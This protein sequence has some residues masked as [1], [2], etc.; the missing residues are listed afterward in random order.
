MEDVDDVCAVI[1]TQGFRI[2]EEYFP[3]EICGVSS[4]SDIH[5]RVKPYKKLSKLRFNNRHR[6]LYSENNVHGLT[7]DTDKGFY[8]NEAIKILKAWCRLQQTPTKKSFG[9]RSDRTYNFLED[10]GLNAVDLRPHGAIMKNLEKYLRELNFCKW[11]H[12]NGKY[13]YCSY[14]LSKAVSFWL[15][16]RGRT[17]FLINT[18]P[19]RERRHSL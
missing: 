2:S 12:E 7:Y 10:N 16:Q 6:V 18:E 4:K 5:L 8:L 9:V 14:A 3:G 17:D 1:D 13:I 11:H 15:A 19:L